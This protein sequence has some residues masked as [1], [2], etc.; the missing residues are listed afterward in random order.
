MSPLRSE[1]MPN[2]KWGLTPDEDYSCGVSPLREPMSSEPSRTDAMD[3]DEMDEEDSATTG[4]AGDS[5]TTGWTSF[6]WSSVWPSATFSRN[7]DDGTKNRFPV[8]ARLKS[9]SRS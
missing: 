1:P 3:E 5:T 8:T 2:R 6:A 4:A 7:V 9:S